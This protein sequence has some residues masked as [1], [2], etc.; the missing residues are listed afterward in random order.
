VDIII[1]DSPLYIGE[2]VYV[3]YKGLEYEKY[4]I[5]DMTIGTGNRIILVTGQNYLHEY[6]TNRHAT[7]NSFD[8]PRML[9]EA[10][11]NAV[12]F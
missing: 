11:T 8:F 5:V 1:K 10:P 2:F 12:F 4:K 7:F 6:A 9:K 3:H